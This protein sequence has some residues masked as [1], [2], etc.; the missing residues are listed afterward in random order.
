MGAGLP[1][2]QRQTLMFSG[3]TKLAEEGTRGASGGCSNW[4]RRRI[5]STTADSTWGM[6]T[7]PSGLGHCLHI[8]FRITHRAGSLPARKDAAENA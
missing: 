3:M 6:A 1:T 4:E 2:F 7:I 8:A 5:T